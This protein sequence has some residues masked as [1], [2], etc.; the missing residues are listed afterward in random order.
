MVILEPRTHKTKCYK[1]EKERKK[2]YYDDDNNNNIN[3]QHS[4]KIRTKRSEQ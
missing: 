3:K 2:Y 4:Y 1:N